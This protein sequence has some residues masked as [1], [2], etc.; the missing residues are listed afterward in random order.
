M[1]NEIHALEI[2]TFSEKNGKKKIE[3]NDVDLR[4][5]QRY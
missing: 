4:T 1:T 5:N 3:V 2:K